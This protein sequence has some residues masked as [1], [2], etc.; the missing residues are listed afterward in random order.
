M[1]THLGKAWRPLGL[2]CDP[3]LD[4]KEL[5]VVP[6]RDASKGRVIHVSEE[7]LAST[8]SH[9][10]AILVVAVHPI[11]VVDQGRHPRVA[12]IFLVIVVRIKQDTEPINLLSVPERSPKLTVCG[13]IP[14]RLHPG[15]I[16]REASALRQWVC[17][18]MQCTQMGRPGTKGPTHKSVTKERFALPVD[19]KV[20]RCFPRLARETVW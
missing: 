5:Q 11:A 13:S 12:V 3:H 19:R 7:R 4:F 20:N 14:E 9:L 1:W 2:L 10:L 6:V 16:N 17:D 8:A 18:A 15:E